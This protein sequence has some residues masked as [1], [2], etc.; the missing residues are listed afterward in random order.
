MMRRE[1]I[2]G[3]FNPGDILLIFPGYPMSRQVHLAYSW[4]RGLLKKDEFLL[5]ALLQ[6][7]SYFGILKKHEVK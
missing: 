1:S 2:C 5:Q 4:G 6:E 7:K 3:I